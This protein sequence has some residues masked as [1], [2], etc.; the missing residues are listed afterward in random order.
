[1]WKRLSIAVW[2]LCLSTALALAGGWNSR[3]STYNNASSFTPPA[4]MITPVVSSTSPLTSGGSTFF[5]PPVGSFSIATIGTGGLNRRVPIP[6]SGT[7]FGV[8]AHL[9]TAMTTASFVDQHNTSTGTVGCNFSAGVDCNSGA[10]TE[11]FTAGDFL[12]WV[13]TPGGTWAQSGSAPQVN[14][15]L[16]QAD[17]GASS[18]MMLSGPTNTAIGGA[19]VNIFMP[20]GTVYNSANAAT[21]A[22]ASSIMPAAGS[23]SGLYVISNATEHATNPHVY[24]LV[25]NGTNTGLTC[26]P[27]AGTSTGCCINVG[28][29]GAIS[30]GPSCSSGSAV[31]I[32][33]GDTI[34]LNVNCAS[35]TCNSVSPGASVIWNPTTPGQAVFQATNNSAGPSPLFT[36]MSDALF[37]TTQT[38]WQIAPFLGSTMTLSNLIYCVQ[39]APT[40]VTSRTATTQFNTVPGT[41]P[42][43]NSALT[44]TFSSSTPC[45]GANSG[46]ML[47]GSQDTT[48]TFT[49][50]AS[51]SLDHSL[52]ISGSPPAS[53]YIKLGVVATVP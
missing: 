17:S 50:N 30:A 24:T 28:G 35:A 43:T 13:W 33:V 32:A 18:G 15:W 19:A 3:D 48:H 11:H 20:F 16:F 27:A 31:S 44:T 14:S 21:E 36:G 51:Y 25:K 2:A 41:A 12:Q 10:A 45:P 8:V 34:S 4:G 5:M 49:V 7:L 46:V 52:T 22:L 6:I 26:T 1:M 38:N 39:V 53:G 29:V 9:N 37:S 42:G 47:G 40:G 23:I